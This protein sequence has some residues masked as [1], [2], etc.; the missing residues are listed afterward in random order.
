P[1][2]E[3]TYVNEDGAAEKPKWPTLVGIKNNVA[4][5]ASEERPWE[6]KPDVPEFD[7]KAEYLKWRKDPS[8]EHLCYFGTCSLNP[9]IRPNSKQNPVAKIRALIADYDAKIT[10]EAC[11]TLLERC[12]A[13]L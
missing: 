9:G 13:D 4:T 11:Q 3:T 10:D 1:K 2:S 6:F 7:S 8:T 12:P 5:I